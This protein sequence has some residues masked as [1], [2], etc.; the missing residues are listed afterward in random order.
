MESSRGKHKLSRDH[1]DLSGI[2]P[3]LISPLRSDHP[4]SNRQ[5]N[6]KMPGRHQSAPVDLP[7]LEV[8]PSL[9]GSQHPAGSGT[10]SRQVELSGGSAQQSSNRVASQLSR[11]QSHH[12]K[13][14]GAR[15]NRRVHHQTE[16]AAAHLCQ[17]LPGS[18]GVRHRCPKHGLGHSSLAVPLPSV[19]HPSCGVTEGKAVRQHCHPGH[20]PALA[21]PVMVSRLNQSLHGSSPVP[22]TEGRSSGSGPSLEVLGSPQPRFI[23][24][25]CLAALPNSRSFGEH[26]RPNC[27]A[28]ERLHRMPLQCQVG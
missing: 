22:P 11:F 17:P 14:G 21:S 27:L 2:E 6:L 15:N 5:L 20:R 28:S 26:C 23:P 7:H 24:I 13:M 16:Q 10:S 4:D 1:G 18:S 8:V 12:L 19:S 9:H 25:P 3:L